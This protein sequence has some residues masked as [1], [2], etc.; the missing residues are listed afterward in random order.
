MDGRLVPKQKQQEIKEAM[1]A[2]ARNA[3]GNRLKRKQD[4]KPAE[5]GKDG[6]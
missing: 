3:K 4:E 5:T 1:E 6:K 2:I